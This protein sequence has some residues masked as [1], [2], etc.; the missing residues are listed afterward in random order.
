MKLPKVLRL[1]AVELSK[2][3]FVSH[4][5][6]L[7]AEGK[8]SSV[9]TVTRTG[10]FSD[11]RYGAFEITPQMLAE[12]VSNFD[13]GTYGQDI[14]IDVA[15]NP[16]QG[17]A[18]KITRLAVEGNRLR[19]HVDWT[20]YGVEAVQKRGF[21]YLSAEYHENWQDN[22]GGGAHGP[23]LLGAGLTTRPVIK[24]LDP[25]EL[26]E[27]YTGKH[28]TYLHPQLHK[29]LSEESQQSMNELLKKLRERLEALK[30]SEDT[31]KSILGTYEAG[32]KLLG[33]DEAGQKKLTAE[34]EAMAKQLSE[35]V[36]KGQAVTISLPTP[37]AP[38]AADPPKTLSETDIEA[39]IEKREKARAAAAKKLSEGLEANRKAYADVVEKAEGIPDD[40]K[41]ELQEAGVEI[42][43]ADMQTDTVKKLAAQSLKTA[44]QIVASR[45]LAA[46][47]YQRAGSP[48]IQIQTD[49][50]DNAIKKL[51]ET[52]ERRLGFADMSDS[53]RFSRLG[54]VLR[55]ENK[56]LAEKVLA[57]FDGRNRHLLEREHK[58]LADGPTTVTNVAFPT[59]TERTVIREA[60]YQL[61]G[62]QFVDAG[63]LSFNGSY[64]IP[65]SFRDTAAAG[66][67]DVRRYEKQAINRARM[68]QTTDLAYNIPQKL[69]FDASD[70]LRYLAQGGSVDWDAVAEG[71]RNVVRIIGEDTERLIFNEILH[72]ADEYLATAVSN[73]NLELQ[74]DDTL[75]VFLLAQWPV[76]RPRQVFDLQG[77]QVGSTVNPI[78]VTYNSVVRAEYDGTGTQAAGIYYVINYNLG[79]I[80]L[81]NE[82]GAIQT[83]ANGTAY[84]IS[85]S[86][87]TNTFKFNTDIGS[88]AID[89]H[90]NTF[91]YRFG[92]RKSV[93]EDER[94]H[95]AN[96]ALLSGTAMT[97]VEQA[98]QFS[99]NFTRP[100]TDLSATGN[101]GQIKGV[102]AFR[103]TAPALWMGDQRVVIGERFQTRFR[104]TKPWSMSMLEDTRDSNGRFIGAK[105]QYG[106][107]FIVLHTPTQLKR[108][109]TSMVLYSAAAR[110]A[111][112]TP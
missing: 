106:D 85:Y 46:M 32:L 55:D 82:A 96:H 84:T 26:S 103:T 5:H 35:V 60:L 53:R 71:S 102:P 16:D 10:S 81:V 72:A 2:R 15:H 105:E 66:V 41:K 25:V 3:R 11:P 51:Q 12:M 74:A 52:A 80:Y 98:K 7:L 8:K 97:Q 62:L 57:D 90:W 87:A 89:D 6:V 59:I 50:S 42:I 14:M 30:L 20:D 101:L 28:P 65:Y 1:S 4:P 88:S 56:K 79:E 73:E 39:L 61:V 58:L 68:I 45:K 19:A 49:A 78:T 86:Y 24:R 91:L 31:I 108:A 100:G 107:Q 83:P 69:A 48:H 99:A 17:A 77:N 34:Y 13:D 44:E 33:E 47:G 64:T 70:E 37:A 67:N 23:V 93:I 112:V 63:T 75:N 104:M 92:L 40:L 18:G 38:P 95:M 9:V 27:T 21:Q 94:F 111:R 22:E 43:T 110:V 76:V 109:Y 29:Q 36:S 54:G